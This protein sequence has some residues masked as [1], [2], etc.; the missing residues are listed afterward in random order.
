LF[1]IP[2]LVSN[3]DSNTLKFTLKN[4]KTGEVRSPVYILPGKTA[5]F[6]L[7]NSKKAVKRHRLYSVYDE[8]CYYYDLELIKQELERLQKQRRRGIIGE[9]IARAFDQFFFKGKIGLAVDVLNI[10]CCREGEY[11]HFQAQSI[12]NNRIAR[13]GQKKQT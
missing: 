5:T 9:A 10:Y 11:P 6:S 4:L 3:T 1:A 7:K 8:M 13:T 2:A 12:I